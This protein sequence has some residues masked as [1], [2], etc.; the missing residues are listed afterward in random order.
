MGN[1]LFEAFEIKNYLLFLD[2][3]NN[4][5]IRLLLTTVSNLKLGLKVNHSM[6]VFINKK[7]HFHF[8]N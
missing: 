7:F 5:Q 3:L 4:I 6:P 8:L 2:F 1:I